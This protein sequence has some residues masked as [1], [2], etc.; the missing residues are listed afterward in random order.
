MAT[1]AGTKVPFKPLDPDKLSVP[2]RDALVEWS[3][4]WYRRR[5]EAQAAAQK[6]AERKRE[7]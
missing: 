1:L 5:N 4:D 7:N 2:E 3:N 6:D